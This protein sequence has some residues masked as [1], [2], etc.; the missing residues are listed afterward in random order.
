MGLIGNLQDFLDG[1][2]ALSQG[3]Y[4]HR[5]KQTWA[6]IHASSEIRTHYPSVWEGEDIL[7]LTERSYSEDFNREWKLQTCFMVNKKQFFMN[8]SKILV[9]SKKYLSRRSR[10]PQVSHIDVPFPV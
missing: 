1:G 2:S 5:S 7:C 8:I 9:R 6:D 10:R 4:L 3:R